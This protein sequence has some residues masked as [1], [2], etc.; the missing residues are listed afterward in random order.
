MNEREMKMQDDPV[1]KLFSGTKIKAGDNLKYRI[2]QQI[3]T[4]SALSVKKS[5]SK[6]LFP[7]I[8]NMFS[9]FGVMYALIVLV[10]I[11]VV[12]VGGVEALSSLT[13]FVPIIMIA[14]VCG[15]FLMIS[16]YDDKRRLKHFKEN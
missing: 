15:L 4:E 12:L 5:K 10:A 7:L 14:S 16:V 3:E 9:V 2:M 13:F 6:S 1:R 8:G 11:G